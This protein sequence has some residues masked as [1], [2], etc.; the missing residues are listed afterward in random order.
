MRK[1][2]LLVAA[3]LP[4]TGCSSGS[5][6]PASP[7]PVAQSDNGRWAIVP[8]GGPPEQTGDERLMY[9]W[10]IDTKTG[11]VEMCS[12][13]DGS[14][15]WDPTNRADIHGPQLACSLE[16]KATGGD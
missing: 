6:A 2:F 8:S 7:A 11:T 1:L 13:T 10:R 16:S 4:L 3:V 15:K 5:P 9:A 14:P 12:Y